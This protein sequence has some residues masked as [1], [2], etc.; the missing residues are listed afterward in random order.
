MIDMTV[1]LNGLS[2]P[3][4]S[5]ETS[6]RRY[7]RAILVH[8][9]MPEYPVY[10]RGSGLPIRYRGRYFLVCTQHQLKDD[11][12]FERVSIEHKG[13]LITSGGARSYITNDGDSDY[14]DIVAFDYSEPCAQ[15][16]ELRSTF[17][18]L[19]KLPNEG[20][21]EKIAFSIAAGYATVDQKYEIDELNH[22]GL[23]RRTV[24]C[25]LDGQ[26]TDNAVLRLKCVNPLKIN[27][28]GLS[29]GPAFVI[30]FVGLRHAEAV[31]GGMILRA[32]GDYLH[33]L[34]VGVIANFLDAYVNQADG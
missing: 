9:D 10:I 14:R 30:Q 24:V 21:S 2:I 15:L 26:S 6:L 19:S 20:T 13:A 34:K 11:V 18:D 1:A 8:T 17:F 3:A 23:A 27:P 29:G 12:D 28:D 32:G 33:I 5:I 25:E 16:P 4:G 7:A 31:L 22:L